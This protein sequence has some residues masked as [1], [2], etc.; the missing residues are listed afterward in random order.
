MLFVESTSRTAADA[1]AYNH[2]KEMVV[3]HTGL[4][5]G[6]TIYLDYTLTS[7]PGYLPE[8]DI[9]NE[10]LQ[11]SPVKEY[12]HQSVCTGKQTVILHFAV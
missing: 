2:L 9:Y 4:E 12:T 5:L 6:A 1:P 11:T 7:K 3:V 10:L 8:L